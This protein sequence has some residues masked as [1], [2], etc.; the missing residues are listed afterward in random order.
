MS[1]F[2]ELRHM[3]IKA[4]WSVVRRKITTLLS[5]FRKP[6]ESNQ[7]VRQR[8]RVERSMFQAAANYAVLQYPGRILTFVASQ[9]IDP[10]DTRYAWRELADGGCQTVEIA[11][12][13]TGELVESPHVE[14]ISSHICRYV[15]EYFSDTPISSRDKAA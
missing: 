2:S 8:K 11:A 15:A 12:R 4:R 5:L 9:R 10:Q 7:K 13:Y 1:V 14:R 6:P 3:P